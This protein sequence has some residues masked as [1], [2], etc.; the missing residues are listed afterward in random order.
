MSNL[1]LEVFESNKTI[2]PI[3]FFLFINLYPQNRYQVFNR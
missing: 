3:S 1:K 2:E